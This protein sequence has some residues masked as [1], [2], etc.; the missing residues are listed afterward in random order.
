MSEVTD[1]VLPVL[2]RVQADLAEVKREIAESAPFRP[3]TASGSTT[4]KSIWPMRRGWLPRARPTWKREIR[5]PGYQAAP[6][7][8]RDEPLSGSGVA[9]GWQ[10]RD[11][12]ERGWLD[13]QNANAREHWI[14]G[15]KVHLGTMPDTRTRPR[16][17]GSKDDRI[18]RPGPGQR[19]PPI[20]IALIGRRLPPWTGGRSR[21]NS[22][23]GSRPGGWRAGSSAA[24]G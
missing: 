12:R 7:N 13:L 14:A 22:G 1:L 9:S 21:P 4:W 17:T 15:S 2:Q 10:C 18:T 23:S 19:K 20:R 6:R 11:S 16:R 8:A 5:N 3:S 24:A